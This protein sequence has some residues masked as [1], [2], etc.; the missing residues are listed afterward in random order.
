MNVYVLGKTFLLLARELCINAPAIGTVGPVGREGGTRD[1]DPQ[2]GHWCLEPAS[3]ESRMPRSVPGRC[4]WDP[5]NKGLV[6]GK[7]PADRAS[8]S[9]RVG[10]YGSFTTGTAFTVSWRDC[11]VAHGCLEA[12]F[13]VLRM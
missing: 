10:L 1:E 2:G 13:L 8:L 11:S 3:H 6:D 9:V 4:E 7:A 5:C 12:H